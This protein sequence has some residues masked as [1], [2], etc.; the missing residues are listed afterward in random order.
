VFKSSLACAASSESRWLG[1]G[2]AVTLKVEGRFYLKHGHGQP[3]LAVPVAL[4]RRPKQQPAP[5]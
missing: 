2:Y 1:S 4:D 5:A 3:G